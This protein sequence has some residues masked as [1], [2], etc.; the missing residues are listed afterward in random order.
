MFEETQHLQLSKNPL[1][2]NEVLEDIGH[3]FQGDSLSISGVCHWPERRERG[4]TEWDSYVEPTPKYFQWF[5]SH[6]KRI[7]CS[8]F[9]LACLLISEEIWHVCVEPG[10][11]ELLVFWRRP[12]IPDSLV[13]LERP[14][15]WI[16]FIRKTVQ[17]SSIQC[18]WWTEFKYKKCFDFCQFVTKEL[19][20]FSSF[21]GFFCNGPHTSRPPLNV[22]KNNLNSH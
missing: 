16:P 3:L 8:G 1:T 5:W 17:F 12:W 14:F 2:G 15:I 11:D 21:Q 4:V 18:Y 19:N 20:R 13:T 10:L 6:G 7:G 22:V 9:T